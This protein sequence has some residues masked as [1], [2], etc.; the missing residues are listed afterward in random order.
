[1]PKRK[2]CVVILCYTMCVMKPKK[3]YKKT[4]FKAQTH[5]SLSF[6]EFYFLKGQSSKTKQ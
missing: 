6:V 2:Y 4:L 1:M 3:S 5:E